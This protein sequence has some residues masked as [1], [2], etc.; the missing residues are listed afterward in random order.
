MTFTN[1]LKQERQYLHFFYNVSIIYYKEKKIKNKKKERKKEKNKFL[2]S[3]PNTH[4]PE[5]QK[6]PQV[7]CYIMTHE[8]I[9]VLRFSDSQV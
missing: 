8:Q 6:T 5:K 2:D 3:T 1:R 4:T 7:V 9:N